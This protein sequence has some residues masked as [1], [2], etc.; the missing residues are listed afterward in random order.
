MD[1]NNRS[2]ES[3]N[4]I[5]RR[6]FGIQAIGMAAVA[7]GPMASADAQST[8]QTVSRRD[9]LIME[10]PPA[11]TSFRN[12]NN[13]NPFAVG[14]DIRNH[15]VFIQ[16][17]LFYWSNL[18]AEH[19]PYLATGYRFNDSNTEVLVSLRGGVKWS[20]GTRF[21]A[22]DVVFTFEM[23]RKNGG[24]A[25]TL[26]MAQ[27]V[28]ELVKVTER[29]DELTVRFVLQKPDPRFV[30]RIL[31][32]K[33]NNGIHPVPAHVFG[34]VEDPATFT[35]LDLASGVPVGTGPYRIVVA[36]PSRIVLDR[37]DD[38]WGV[39]PGVWGDKSAAFYAKLPA[40]R[41]IIAVPRNDMQQAAQ[42]LAAK[43][44]DWMA[45]ASVPVMRQL[46]AQHRH[47]TTLTDRKAP[48]GNLDWWPTSLHF[49]HDAPLVQD[50]RVRLAIRYAVNVAQIIEIFHDGAADP[51]FTPLPDFKSLRPYID[52]LAPVAKEREINVFDL[53]KSAR[54]MNE[55]GYQKDRAGYW[56]KDGA[57]WEAT[58]Y[59]P[60]ALEGIGPIV[61]EQLRRA[62]FDVKWI[63]S[64]DVNQIM[65]T[66]RMVIALWG[67]HGS[68]YDPEDSML[69][70]HSRYYRPVG[71]FTTRLNRWRNQRFDQLT[72]QVGALPPNDPRIR[73]LVKEAFTIWMDEVVEVPIAQWYHR[74]PFSTAYWQG[75]PS[76][77][78]PHTPPTVAHWTTGLLVRGLRAAN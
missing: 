71:E 9:T 28:A 74:V 58:V 47:I 34:K 3:G 4:R 32:V 41:R 78:D 69:F 77:S 18:T 75:W 29:V 22:D 54:L 19:I 33:F 72:D 68:V 11:G 35:N 60:R 39:A 46:L 10:A 59:G 14:G 27:D 31:T 24:G 73:P 61:A 50:R 30:L 62:G 55:A 45:E 16:E 43:D 44:L 67:H 2:K 25:N 49:N 63:M 6:D 64:A 5:S 48:Y 51:L 15:F 66:G 40:P 8:L 7:A 65:Y 38:W 26:F 17:A 56:T 76:E 57:R 23:L 1:I 37:R 13:A 36:E 12:Y 53:T 52:D 42:R 20:D 70:Y 21:T